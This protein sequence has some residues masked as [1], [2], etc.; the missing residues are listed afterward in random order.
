VDDIGLLKRQLDRAAGQLGELSAPPA[1]ADFERRRRHRRR[2]GWSILAAA[3]TVVALVSAVSA[4]NDG[5]SGHGTAVANPTRGNT[6]SAAATPSPVSPD[7]SA[8]AIA[9][10]KWSTLPAA[11]IA[12]REYAASAWT[13]SQLV[14]WG[15][16]PATQTFQAFKDGA[17]YNPKTRTWTTLPASPLSARTQPAFVWTAT[18]LFIWGGLVPGSGQAIDRATDGALYDPASKSWKRLA[19][20]PVSG[21]QQAQALWTGSQVILLTTPPG[22]STDIVH[23]DAYDPKSNRWTTRPDLKLPA[24]HPLEQ[25]TSVVTGSAVYLWSYWA[26][27]NGEST[28]FGVDGFVLAGDASKW[29]A[30]SP[31]VANAGQGSPLS[32]G[33]D[34]VVPPILDRWCGACP[35]P[36]RLQADP[37]ELLDP[38][39]ST[40]HAISPGPVSGLG[41]HYL[42]TGAALLAYDTGTFSSSGS[43]VTY[44][45]KSAVWDP[46]TSTWTRLP[47]APLTSADGA[48]TVWTGSS[49]LI[50]G[51]LDTIVHDGSVEHSPTSKPT[52]AGLQ[53]G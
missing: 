36:A 39:T 51:V 41:P 1:I 48:A 13:G 9:H 43:S 53:L 46:A 49:L 35:G 38:V 10:D 34:I 30:A 23:V 25:F 47:D 4:V 8:S 12:G 44:P 26:D 21:Y 22:N 14:V 28:S 6:G 52:T 7:A 17:A 3:G 18:D 27:T 15:G 32:T 24:H 11:P 2:T 29:T 33:R 40:A 20:G 31:R 50:W 42:W 5:H 45:G 37:G 16:D 19:P